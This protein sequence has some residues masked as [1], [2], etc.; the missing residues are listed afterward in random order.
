ML[1]LI[2]LLPLY[3]YLWYEEQF[4][5]LCLEVHTMARVVHVKSA[6][7]RHFDAGNES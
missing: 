4:C 6:E 7:G 5:S 1:K 2:S 3:T